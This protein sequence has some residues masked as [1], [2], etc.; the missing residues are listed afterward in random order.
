[1]IYDINHV[2]GNEEMPYYVTCSGCREKYE[3]I[4][5]S[6]QY[7]LYKKGK[8]TYFTCEKC[9]QKIRLNAIKHLFGTGNISIIDNQ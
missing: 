2:K 7:Q 6:L 8:T 3:L 4:E 1:V 9:N 5:G